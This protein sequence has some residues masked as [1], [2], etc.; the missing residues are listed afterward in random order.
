LAIFSHASAVTG[1]GARSASLSHSTAFGDKALLGTKAFA[2]SK[3][4]R[5]S[6][7][8]VSDVEFYLASAIELRL[9]RRGITP[10]EAT[11]PASFRHG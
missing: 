7:V 2:I 4:T 3:T 6:P 5:L 10:P 9:Q 11:R 1:D 8:P